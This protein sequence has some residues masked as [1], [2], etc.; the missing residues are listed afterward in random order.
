ML[1]EYFQGKHSHIGTIGFC[2]HDGLG[3]VLGSKSSGVLVR[4][5]FRKSVPVGGRRLYEN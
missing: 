5:V 4:I 3:Q 1:Q 2:F